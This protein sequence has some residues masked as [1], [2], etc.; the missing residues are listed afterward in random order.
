MSITKVIDFQKIYGNMIF[1]VIIVGFS[2][3]LYALRTHA[4]LSQKELAEKLGVAQASINYWEK[5]QRTPSI[6]MVVLIAKYFNVSL[7]DLLG[8]AQSNITDSVN[9]LAAHFDG[10]QYT[11]EE[12]NRIMEYA[13]FVKSMRANKEDK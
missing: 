6:D 3:N 9:T 13:K 7:D 10:E 8:T 12:M 1:E 11:K 5:G 2:E 4:S